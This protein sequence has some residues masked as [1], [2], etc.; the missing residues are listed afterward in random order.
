MQGKSI[1]VVDDST[2][3]S[4]AGTMEL[5][6][7]LKVELQQQEIIALDHTIT[8]RHSIATSIHSYE[9]PDLRFCTISPQIHHIN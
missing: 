7:C 5:H 3:G 4:I 1:R 2:G 9:Y 6:S 8:I